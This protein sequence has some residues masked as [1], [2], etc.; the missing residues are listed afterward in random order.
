MHDVDSDI[1]HMVRIVEGFLEADLGAKAEK[2]ADIAVELMDSRRRF[3]RDAYWGVNADSYQAEIE[4]LADKTVDDDAATEAALANTPS[5]VVSAAH[6]AADDAGNI[7]VDE[8][9]APPFD[10]DVSEVTADA[11][12]AELVY[13]ETADATKANTP[14]KITPAELREEAKRAASSWRWYH[15][16]KSEPEDA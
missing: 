8:P 13:V 9:A 11:E 7:A 3:R 6:E 10:D 12:P 16:H 2:Y 14:I 15:P 1:A 5:P 4:R